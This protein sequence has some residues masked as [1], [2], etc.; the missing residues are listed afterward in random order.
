MSL[1][2][3]KKSHDPMPLIEEGGSVHLYL[4]A[5]HDWL[6]K[7]FERRDYARP[8]VLY[9]TNTGTAFP[10]GS[11]RTLDLYDEDGSLAYKNAVVRNMHPMPDV[12]ADAPMLIG[13]GRAKWIVL[14]EICATS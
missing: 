8:G 10:A 12:S 1:H 3:R 5:L 11:E 13:R 6:R 9:A 2:A 7:Q 4:R 14:G